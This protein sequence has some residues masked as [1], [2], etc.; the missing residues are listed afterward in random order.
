MVILGTP[1][2]EVEWKGEWFCGV[3]FFRSYFKVELEKGV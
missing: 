1:K 2:Q 3:N